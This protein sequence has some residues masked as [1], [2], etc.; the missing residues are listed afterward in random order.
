MSVLI[1][2]FIKTAV[3]RK[4]VESVARHIFV[5]GGA[6]LVSQGYIDQ[7]ASQMLIGGGSSLVGGIWAIWSKRLL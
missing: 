7:D 3:T 1:G 5:T 6:F 2:T 4:A